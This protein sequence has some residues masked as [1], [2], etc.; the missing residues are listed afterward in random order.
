MQWLIIS[1]PIAF[2]VLDGILLQ[3][4]AGLCSSQIDPQKHNASAFHGIHEPFLYRLV[5]VLADI[6][7]KPYPQLQQRREDISSVILAE[8]KN[9][10]AVIDTSNSV[11]KKNT[12]VSKVVPTHGRQER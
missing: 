1:G 3:T 6:M 4:K 8:E 7:K 2:S 9:F 10:I 11:L 5:P 12:P